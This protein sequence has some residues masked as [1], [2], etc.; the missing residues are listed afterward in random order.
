M[1][2]STG[3]RN[4]FRGQADNVV[5]TRNLHG[6]VHVHRPVPAPWPTPRQLPMDVL[7][8]VGRTAELGE[9][10]TLY[11][12]AVAR[13]GTVPILTLSGPAGAGKSALALRWAHR[14]QDLFPDGHLYA[15]LRKPKC[16]ITGFLRA[17]DIPEERVPGEPDDLAAL[18]RSVLNR[19]RVLVLLDN[20]ADAEQVQPLLPAWPGCTV[21]VTSRKDAQ[22]VSQQI[23]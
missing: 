9:L 5:Q 22:A 2:R 18:F 12:R 6:D 11:L 21:L 3:T 13:P 23:N 4:S 14:T 15:D 7:N 10:D 1:R 8:F 16:A 20:A 19:K 17:F